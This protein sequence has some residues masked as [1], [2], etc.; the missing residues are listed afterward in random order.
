[1]PYYERKAEAELRLIEALDFL[2]ADRRTQLLEAI[3]EYISNEIADH[4]DSYVHK[5]SADRW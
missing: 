1:M 2:E 5:P 3:K 4:K